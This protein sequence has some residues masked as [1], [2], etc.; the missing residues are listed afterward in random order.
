MHLVGLSGAEL[1]YS[2]CSWNLEPLSAN[3]TFVCLGTFRVNFTGNLE[4]FAPRTDII[5]VGCH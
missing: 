5:F 4:D 2:S 3:E 1:P